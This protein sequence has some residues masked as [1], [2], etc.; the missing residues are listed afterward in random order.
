MTGIDHINDMIQK[1]KEWCF[2]DIQ[3]GYETKLIPCSFSEKDIDVFA[4]LSGDHNPLHADDTF[5]RDK[6]YKRRVV[7]GML[8]ASKFSYLVGMIIP[9]KNCLYL[10]Q[11][12]RF[13]KPLYAG[14]VCTL[15]GTV[16]NKSESTKLLEIKT[17]IFDA[18]NA[19]V[20]SGIAKVQVT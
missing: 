15:K 5:A 1:P 9:G 7:H 8:S 12:I 18:E 17:E 6:G 20:V 16:I 10:S 13:H 3:A 14:E 4:E 2:E 19:L 11:E